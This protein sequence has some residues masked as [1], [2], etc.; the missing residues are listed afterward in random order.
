MKE[1]TSNS[2]IENVR[3]PVCLSPVSGCHSQEMV[4]TI[5]G[6]V[7]PFTIPTCAMY[8]HVRGTVTGS[9]C[10]IV[11]CPLLPSRVCFRDKDTVSPHC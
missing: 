2:V 11:L 4:C 1:N 6:P 10:T 5:S 9:H 7:L 8:V 3:S